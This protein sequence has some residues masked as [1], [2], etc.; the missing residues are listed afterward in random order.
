MVRATLGI[1]RQPFRRLDP[2]ISHPA[3]R[4][5]A[6]SDQQPRARSGRSA[7]HAIRIATWGPNED[8]ARGLTTTFPLGLRYQETSLGTLERQTT[9]GVFLLRPR[10]VRLECS[11]A[12]AKASLP[13][14]TRRKS[15]AIS[16][17]PLENCACTACSCT[18]PS[19]D[20]VWLKHRPRHECRFIPAWGATFLTRRNDLLPLNRTVQAAHLRSYSAGLA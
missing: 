2:R 11:H 19:T 7:P 16:G 6:F 1:P 14:T 12:Y 15:G 3:C 5:R 9:H 17:A 8:D 13:P 4:L 20:P 10:S 18:M